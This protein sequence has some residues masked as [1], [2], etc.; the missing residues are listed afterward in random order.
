MK[1]DLVD[2]PSEI[3]RAKIYETVEDQLKSKNYNLDLSAAAN[4]GDTNYIGI[5]Y[6]LSFCKIEENSEENAKSATH[7]LI[8]KIAP[9]NLIRRARFFSRAAFLREIQVY[10]NVRHIF[11]NE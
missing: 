1:S 7:K 8:I 4:D 3:V 9:Q 10:E 11:H 5:L 2:I 6:R